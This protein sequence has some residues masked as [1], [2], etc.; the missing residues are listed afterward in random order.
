MDYTNIDDDDDED[1]IPVTHVCRAWRKF[2]ISRSSLWTNFYCR[3][4]DKIRVYL[5]RSNSSPI[6]VLL[7]RNGALSIGDPLFQIVPHYAARF[8]SLSIAA[9]P[10]ILRDIFAHLPPHIPLL[11]KLD[12]DGGFGPEA[13]HDLHD[14]FLTTSLFNGDLSSLRVFRLESVRTG[15][16]WRNMVNL[17]VLVLRNMSSD[18]LSIRQLLDFFESAPRPCKVKLDSATPTTGGRSGRLVS[19]AF[20]Q[21]MEILF[22]PPSPHLLSHLLVPVGAELSIWGDSFLHIVRDHLPRSLDNLRNI[23]NITKIHFHITNHT[24]M[25]LGGPSGKLSMASGIGAACLGLE[26]L[27]RLDTSKVEQLEVVSSDHSLT[28]SYRTLLPLKNLRTLT[29]SRCRNQNT[30]IAALGPN[31]GKASG[32]VACPNLE[33]VVLDLRIDTGIDVKNIAK[34]AAA[35]ASR[36]A[37]L[38]TV[39]IIGGKGKLG[40]GELR[41][42][43]LNVEC[44]PVVDVVDSDSD[45]SDEDFW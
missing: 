1:L 40:L 15:L 20:L 5:E 14:P 30:F 26:A 7:Y 31:T 10:K 44:D 34:I 39:R 45:D 3:S 25:E 13:L 2:F 41:K 9:S 11:E 18:S 4:A 6:N 42:H 17:T 37:K 19:L 35:R 27:G 32:V 23:S 36:G 33:E 12:V 24:R 29:L 21:R 38:R 22:G 8:R 43:V 28:P 16:P